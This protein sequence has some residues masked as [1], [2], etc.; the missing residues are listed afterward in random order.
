MDELGVILLQ[1]NP[2]REKVRYE[3]QDISTDLDDVL[4]AELDHEGNSPR[5]VR[6]CPQD[7]AQGLLP[8]FPIV[9]PCHPACEDESLRW[10]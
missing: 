2:H 3:C 10:G 4:S 7:L 1:T 8:Q 9:V 6:F 5:Y